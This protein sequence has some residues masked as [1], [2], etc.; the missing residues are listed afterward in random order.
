MVEIIAGTSASTI[1]EHHNITSMG[2]INP[3]PHHAEW[4]LSGAAGLTNP[5]L[6]RSTHACMYVGT[7]CLSWKAYY[8]YTHVCTRYNASNQCNYTRST[9][10]DSVTP[11]VVRSLSGDITS[12]SA[13]ITY[14]MRSI[15]TFQADTTIHRMW[16]MCIL[17]VYCIRTYFT[18]Y[19]Y[20]NPPRG[21]LGTF[22]SR[23][24]VARTAQRYTNGKTSGLA[25]AD[26]RTNGAQR[27]SR[28]DSVP[29]RYPPRDTVAL[30]PLLRQHGAGRA[31]KKKLTTASL[32]VKSRSRRRG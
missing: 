19:A 30:E 2:E 14:C 7:S 21:W 9:A 3:L 20:E 8:I 25:E 22:F 10:H 27:G 16:R 23:A 1:G 28:R 26:G 31:G 4:V 17:H 11:S 24:G 29:R 15:I 32:T 18:V 5:L 12:T 13:C 6:R